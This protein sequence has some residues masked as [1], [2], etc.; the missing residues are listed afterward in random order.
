MICCPPGRCRMCL[1]LASTLIFRKTNAEKSCDRVSVSFTGDSSQE[2]AVAQVVYRCSLH[3]SS[4]LSAHGVTVPLFRKPASF[5]TRSLRFCDCCIYL[6]LNIFV[7]N[8]TG[9]LSPTSVLN[10]LHDLFFFFVSLLNRN[11]AITITIFVDE[12]I[13]PRQYVVC[14]HI[15]NT[16]NCIAG[17]QTLFAIQQNLECGREKAVNNTMKRD[18]TTHVLGPTSRMIS[19]WEQFSTSGFGETS[20]T[21]PSL[22]HSL[23]P[24]GTVRST[25]AIHKLVKVKGNTSSRACT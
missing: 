3:S 5:S 21:A 24:T 13:H 11:L 6:S 1:V 10:V 20:T 14:T 4:S 25:Y 23:T 16:R 15:F 22:Q 17:A 9:L 18:T 19:D 8:L 7:E 12:A 2:E